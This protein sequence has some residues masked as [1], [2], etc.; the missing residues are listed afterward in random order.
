MKW[1]GK[2]HSQEAHRRKKG[3]HGLDRKIRAFAQ[4][5]ASPRRDKRQ[6]T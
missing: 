2:I 3:K 6:R 5:T 1:Y 4:A